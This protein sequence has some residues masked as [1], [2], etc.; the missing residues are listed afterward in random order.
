M[1]WWWRGVKVHGGSEEKKGVVSAVRSIREWKEDEDG[2]TASVAARRR[3]KGWRRRRWQGE[4]RGDRDKEVG[5]AALVAG[6]RNVWRGGGGRRGDWDK[7]MGM[8]VLVV[9]RWRRR[10]W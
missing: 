1:A 5:L 2:M 6:R 8:I 3:R 9:R 10:A 4:A 7:E